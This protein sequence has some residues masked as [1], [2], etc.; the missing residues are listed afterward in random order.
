MNVLCKNVFNLSYNL[1]SKILPKTIDRLSKI[2]KEYYEKCIK[3]RLKL[4]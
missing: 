2:N 3:E 4:S 1:Y